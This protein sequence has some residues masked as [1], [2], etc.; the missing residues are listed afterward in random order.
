MNFPESSVLRYQFRRLILDLLDVCFNLNRILP[1]HSTSI[2]TFLSLGVL[3]YIL[4]ALCLIQHHGFLALYHLRAHGIVEVGYL[5]ECDP[6]LVVFL[7]ILGDDTH[8][9]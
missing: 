3:D 4:K 5:L 6:F 7:C 2:L 9:F 8:L 1:G